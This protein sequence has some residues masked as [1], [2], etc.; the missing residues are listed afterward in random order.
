MRASVWF[1][2]VAFS[3]GKDRLKLDN[4]QRFMEL[5]ASMRGKRFQ[6]VL[7]DYD[8]SRNASDR[9]YYW[10]EI[11]S[12][13]AAYM[14]YPKEEYNEVHNKIKELM[15]VDSTK[16]FTDSEWREYVAGCRRKADS[17]GIMT[18]DKKAI[19]MET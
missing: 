9:K 5:L 7:S 6:L 19:D 10:A 14:G 3:Y 1:G 18:R 11:V 17:L 16:K 8:P 4:P 13:F 15:C 12:T 2:T